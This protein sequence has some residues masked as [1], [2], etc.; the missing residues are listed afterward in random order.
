M[1]EVIYLNP[2]IPMS[3][4][5]NTT[6]ALFDNALDS[7]QM[8][9]EDYAL[10]KPARS[11]SAVRN[12]YAGLLLLAKEALARQA[13]MANLDDVIG[14][15]FKP[16]PDGTGG[17]AMVPDGHQTIDFVTIAKRF[18]DFGIPL[19]KASEAA[20]KELNTVR[21]EIEH[22]YTNK[23]SDVVREVIARAFPLTVQLFRITGED[24]RTRLSG[25]WPTMLEARDLYAAELLRCRETVRAIDWHS[26]TVEQAG[27]RCT[28]CSSALVE[29]RDP[30][31]TAQASMDL[32][33]A[34]CGE[35]LEHDAVIVEVV[36]Y[37]LAGEAYVRYKE[38]FES[39]P[40]FDCP[41]CSNTAYIDTEDSCAVCGETYEWESECV[42]C[43][44][45]ISMEDA[46]AGFENGVCSYCTHLMEKDD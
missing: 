8:G 36:E 40:I 13:P 16:V 1:S 9:V 18:K 6:S 34:S 44:A 38:A 15:R 10:K 14:A 37:A 46:L 33:C 11:L 27:L 7:I 28:E 4:P 31:N 35:D 12:F 25:V 21:N 45:E 5:S 43:Y 20:L 29:Q 42:R 24:P 17:V 26:S 32:T 39:G 41:N 22:R 30:A 2:T 19:D 23:P 3:T